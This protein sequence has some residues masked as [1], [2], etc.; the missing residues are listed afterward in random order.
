MR[1]EK[2]KEVAEKRN[3]RRQKA[4]AARASQ[5]PRG[6]MNPLGRM[7]AGGAPW[8][9]LLATSLKYGVLFVIDVLLQ[10]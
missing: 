8:G 10:K 7:T 3:A 4:V 2:N 5:M 1:E 6:P 9:E